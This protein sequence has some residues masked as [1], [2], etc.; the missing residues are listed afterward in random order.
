MH[1]INATLCKGYYGVSG[2]SDYKKNMSMATAELPVKFGVACHKIVSGGEEGD[3]SKSAHVQQ[4]IVSIIHR[5]KEG[6]QHSEAIDFMDIGTVSGLGG[7]LGS[8]N[9]CNWWDGSE[10]N[11]WV[12]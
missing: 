3:Q 7:N 4:V 1:T 8:S 11:I 9:P 12:D 10:T 5:V 6:L 2:S